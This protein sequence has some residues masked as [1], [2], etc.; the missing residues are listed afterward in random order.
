MLQFL[1]LETEHY[2]RYLERCF[3]QLE[4]QLELEVSKPIQE[5]LASYVWEK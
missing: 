1:L 5:T 4:V 2:S 3:R